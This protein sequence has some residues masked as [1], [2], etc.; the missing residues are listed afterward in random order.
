VKLTPKA[1]AMLQYFVTHP[2]Q[3]VTKEELFQAV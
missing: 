2:G 3:V 1:L